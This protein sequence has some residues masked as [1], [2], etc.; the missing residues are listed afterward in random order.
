MKQ[1]ERPTIALKADERLLWQGQPKQ[2]IHLRKQD[3]FLIPFSLL[4]CGFAVFWTVS[5]L[6]MDAP[7]F[8][9]VIGCVFVG[10]GCYLVF[11]RFLHDS[12]RRRHTWYTLTDKRAIITLTTP[13][14]KEQI[15]DL[16]SASNVSVERGSDGAGS[17]LFGPRLAMP[18][19]AF[20][21]TQ[22]NP[23]TPSFDLVADA[24]T[25]FGLV[26]EARDRIHASKQI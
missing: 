2:G 11:G 23:S 19:S 15:L 7:I 5:V 26:I 6:F 25:I 20:S 21:W 4:W 9:K 13:K 3:A 10:A 17:V 8:M 16:A 1:M 12:Y 14:R 18:F 24:E 22:T